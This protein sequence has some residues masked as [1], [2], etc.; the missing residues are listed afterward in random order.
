MNLHEYQAKQLLKEYGLPVCE[1]VNCSDLNEALQAIKFLQGDK[2]ILK[3]QVHSGARAKAGGVKI[4]NNQ[5]ELEQFFTKHLNQIL[6]TEQ[7]NQGQVVN[8]I[9]VETPC[10]I[11]KEL[12]LSFFIERSEAKIIVLGATGG[13][14]EIE[15][16][17]NNLI[18]KLEIEINLGL[19]NFQARELGFQLGL[20]NKLNQQFVQLLLRAYKLFIEKDLELLEINPLVVSKEELYCLDAKIVVDDNAL[21]RQTKLK[22]IFDQRQLPFLE[23][24]AQKAEL[25]FIALDGNIGCMVNG[26]G[27]AMATMDMIELYGGKAANFLDVGGATTK[28]RVAK[29]LQI[30]LLDPKINTIFINIFGGIVRCDLIAQ[31][32][33]EAVEMVKINIPVV[34]RL[35]GNNAQKACELLKNSDLE[36]TV[37]NDLTQALSLVVSKSREQ[38]GDFN[39]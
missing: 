6:V 2:W 5:T 1:G 35:E 11:E 10:S 34:V 18:S 31:G 24:E 33:I 7:N 30:M 37:A 25:N 36:I 3:C 29:A 38:N 28:E 19:Q 21:F 8:S 4:V 23:Q 32:I 9:Y 13:G 20:E 15:N 12:Y 39:Q 22:E 14:V 26:A 17:A 27:L 16:N